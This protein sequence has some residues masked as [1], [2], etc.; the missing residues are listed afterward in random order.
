MRTVLWCGIHTV[1]DVMMV[2]DPDEQ[3][4]VVPCQ[5]LRESNA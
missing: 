1:V 4:R 2:R 3:G 5:E